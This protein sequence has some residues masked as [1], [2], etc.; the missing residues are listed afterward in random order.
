MTFT[1][2]RRPPIT[3]VADVL[4]EVLEVNQRLQ[5]FLVRYQTLTRNDPQL[6]G[7][8]FNTFKKLLDYTLLALV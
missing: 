5:P 8:V 2:F 7:E 1:S 4:Q 3:T 6:S